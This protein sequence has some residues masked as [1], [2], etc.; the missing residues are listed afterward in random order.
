M[1]A[2]TISVGTELLLGE[3]TDTN[4]THIS[5]QL[6]AIG[7]DLYYRHNVGDNLQRLTGVLRTALSRSDVIVLSGGLGPTA[8]DIT[9]DGIAGITGRPLRRDAAAVE[10]LKRFFAER[11]RVPT[12]SNFKQCEAPEGGKLLPNT[13]GTAPGLF[14]EHE[15]AWIFAI[16]G[17]PPEMR[18]M[19]R[20]S[21]LPRLVERATA[22]G[23]GRLYSRVLRLADIGESNVA[24]LLEDVIEG[25]TDPTIAL[26]ASPGEVK[27]RLA[28][29]SPD[30]AAATQRLD[31]MEALLRERLGAHVYALDEDVME[32]AVGKLLRERNATLATAESCTGGLLASRVTDISG[33][34]DYFLGGVVSYAN[35]AK[36]GVL[37]VPAGVIEEHGAVSEPC[38]RAMAEGVRR[39]MGADWGVATT[40]IA[41]PT[42]GTPEKPVGLVYMAVAGPGGTICQEQTW[43]GTR[44]QFK[45]RVTQMAL[46]LLRKQIIAD[47]E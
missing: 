38:A 23:G 47:G 29:K 33:S 40:G 17:P 4:A 43:P 26:Y 31:A 1:K 13:C 39:C 30:E 5:Q 15:G 6:A 41:G 22:E 16:P 8:D 28:G 37:G 42:G 14:V 11:G 44:D 35:E 2:E 19:L 27:I 18:E 25:Q 12:E 21:V 3:I 45:Q 46:N 20:L 9:R 7:V 36:I 24:N 32:T 34:S 10:H